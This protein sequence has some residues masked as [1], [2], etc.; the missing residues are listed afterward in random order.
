MKNEIEAATAALEALRQEASKIE[1]DITDVAQAADGAAIVRLRNRAS[2]L[3]TLLAAAEVKQLDAKINATQAQLARAVES[4]D[5][6]GARDRAAKEYAEAEQA[7]S[8]AQQHINSLG[9]AARSHN[10][11]IRE[12]KTSIRD[13]HEKRAALVAQLGTPPMSVRNL[14]AAGEKVLA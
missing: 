1:G 3:H 8:D 2:E 9:E 4:K 13:L 10:A 14:S 6:A 5:S 11:N 7:L 12:Q